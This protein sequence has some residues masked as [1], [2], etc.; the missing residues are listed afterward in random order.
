MNKYKLVIHHT[1]LGTILELQACNNAGDHWYAM[2]VTQDA[3]EMVHWQAEHNM[4]AD[5]TEHCYRH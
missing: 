5:V 4:P 1:Q 3:A 2:H